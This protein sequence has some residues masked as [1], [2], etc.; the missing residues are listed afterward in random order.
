[1]VAEKRVSEVERRVMAQR[2]LE[3]MLDDLEGWS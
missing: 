2:E 1:M 3:E